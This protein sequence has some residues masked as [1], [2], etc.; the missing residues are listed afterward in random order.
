MYDIDVCII[1]TGGGSVV[2]PKPDMATEQHEDIAVALG[3]LLL[4]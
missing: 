2:V 1:F 4:S 3:E